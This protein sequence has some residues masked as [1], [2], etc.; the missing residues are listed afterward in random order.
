MVTAIVEVPDGVM[1]G[2]VARG[3]GATL[4]RR[5]ERRAIARE[6]NAAAVARPR[7]QLQL[8]LGGLSGGN[9]GCGRTSLNGPR[10]EG[11]I[12][13]GAQRNSLRRTWRIVCDRQICR[14]LART[15]WIEEK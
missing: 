1:T 14:A 11:W 10:S 4:A 6:R 9:G 15:N 13:G 8:I 12:G 2:G 3:A 7:H 5:A